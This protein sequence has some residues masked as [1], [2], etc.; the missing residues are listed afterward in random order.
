MFPTVSGAH[1]PHIATRGRVDTPQNQM[2]SRTLGYALI[3]GVFAVTAVTAHAFDD[4]RKVVQKTIE[5]VLPP[6]PPPPAPPKIDLTFHP[7][8]PLTPVESTISTP[9]GSVKVEPGPIPA[10]PVVH[11]EGN[12]FVAQVVNKT[13]DLVQKPKSWID[14]KGREINRGFIHLGNE[15]GM[16]WKKF[17]D[18]V[19]KEFFDWLQWLKEQVQ[20]YGLYALAG[21]G[22][23]FLIRGFFGFLFGRRHSRTKFAGYHA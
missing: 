18:K 4:P 16:M 1:L 15:I 17:K 3:V 22:A 21:F 7:D 10:P 2:T 23:L 14:Q 19:E 11:A 13:N 9:Q 12:G 20:K 8:K 6:P 5:R